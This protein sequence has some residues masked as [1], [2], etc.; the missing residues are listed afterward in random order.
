MEE[1]RPVLVD[2]VVFRCLATGIVRPEESGTT[3]AA[4][5]RMSPRARQAFL[6]AYERRMLTLFTHEPSARR[7]S[8]RAGLGCRPGRWPGRSPARTG[9]TGR[10]A[11]NDPARHA[12]VL[13]GMMR[14][15]ITYDIAGDQR[16][17]D[18]A[19]LLSGYGPRVQLSV[20]GC[21]MPLRREAAA[22]RVKLRDL[23]EP[24]EDQ[25]RL[26][27]LDDRAVRGTVV[28]GARVIEERQDFWIIT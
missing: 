10:S 3:P 18:I 19:T 7:V 22:L 20:F 6:A 1:F 4:G 9:L 27:P 26:Y 28:L 24:A 15:L 11:G 17:E 12:E 8:C 23:I 25:I 13:A 2:A 16:R 14:F 5:C 21:D